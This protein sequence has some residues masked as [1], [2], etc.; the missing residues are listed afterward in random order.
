MEMMGRRDK[1]FDLG[2]AN[3]GALIGQVKTPFEPEWLV[4]LIIK[5]DSNRR[6]ADIP[7]KHPATHLSFL[8]ESHLSA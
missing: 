4:G 3:F 2:D 6:K 1:G 5:F 7:R 8:G